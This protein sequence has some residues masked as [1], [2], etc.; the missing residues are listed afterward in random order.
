MT[1]EQAVEYLLRRFLV[2]RPPA[3][4]CDIRAV[5][6]IEQA[7]PGITERAIA[8]GAIEGPR[9]DQVGSEH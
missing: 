1:A 2:D 4:P 5:T 6:A 3:L 8:A 7:W 9:P